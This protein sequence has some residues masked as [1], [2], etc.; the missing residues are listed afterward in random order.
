MFCSL[1]KIDI[2][3]PG[4]LPPLLGIPRFPGLAVFAG[5]VQISLAGND[6]PL[7]GLGNTPENSTSR[8]SIFSP[9]RFQGLA[10]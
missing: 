4:N 3:L 1:D 7:I 8:T 5:L 6:D 2:G 9:Y 10:D